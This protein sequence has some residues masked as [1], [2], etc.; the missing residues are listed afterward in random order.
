[1]T[2]GKWLSAAAL[3]L[4]LCA[5][6]EK[7]TAEAGVQT[8]Q[9][10]LVQEIQP[11]EPERYSAVMLPNLQVDLAFKSA[12]LIAHVHQV[13]GADGRRRDVEP[14]DK[15]AA[16]TVLASVRALDYEQKIELG[17]DGV[18]QALAQLAQAKVSFADSELDYTRAKNL[19]SSASL[20]KPDFDRAQA[21]YDSNK[22]Q[23]DAAQSAVDSA[24]TQL[25]QAK[26][27]LE[28]TVLRAPF[29]GYVTARNISK[30]SLVGNST[31]GFSLI[32]THVVKADF[33]VPDTS[34]RGVQLG[35]KL[36]VNLDALPNAPSGVVT[37]ISP[38]A[39]PKSRVFSV[40]VSLANASGVIRPGMIGSLSLAREAHPASRLVIPLSAVVRAPGNPQGFGVFRI[41]E[42]SGKT[43]AAAQAVQIG[44]T[45]GNA[46]QVTSGLAKGDR[47]VALGGELL[48][49]EQEIRVLQ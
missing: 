17:Q 22:A 34:L 33:A 35:Q 30:G 20:T 7:R 38:Q 46:I 26:V 39:D 15:V 1:M 8:V 31:V 42:K 19:Y 48:Q 2:N 32:D 9:A 4:A 27:A 14:G 43:Y 18:T 36:A 41:A 47:I 11:S 24:R 25:N 13:T 12:G 21:H 40:E 23:V 29:T 6:S 49:N 45:Y 44:D 28:D 10:G 3:L 5:C 16:G 37:S